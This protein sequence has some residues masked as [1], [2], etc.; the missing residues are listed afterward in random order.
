MY[1]PRLHKHVTCVYG[2]SVGG[3]GCVRQSSII[4]RERHVAKDI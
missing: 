3:V 1:L 2:H 4:T